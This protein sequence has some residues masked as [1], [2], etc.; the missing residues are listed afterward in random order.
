MY[1]LL[2][3]IVALLLLLMVIP[4]SA[5]QVRVF[6]E[7]VSVVGVQ[8]RDEMKLTVQTLLAS[9]LSGDNIIAVG[10]PGD[11]DVLVKSTYVTVGKVFSVDAVARTSGGST[12]TR[13]FVQGESQDELIPSVGKLAEKLSTELIR[14]NQGSGMSSFANAKA[15][16]APSSEIIKHDQQQVRRAPAGD[17]IKPIYEQRSTGGWLSKRLTG[18]ANLIALGKSLNDGSREV[19]M[20]EN[21]RLSYYRQGTDIKLSAEV[22]FSSAEKII[23]L[24][25]VEAGDGEQ[26][27][28]VTMVR[29][30]EPASQVWRVKGE[31]LVRVAEKIPYFFRAIN[32][33]G[34]PKKLYAQ[35]MGRDTDFYGD[36][37][38]AS[39]SGSNIITKNPLKM[40]QY[41]NIYSFN[42]FRDN[43]GKI[44]TAA[45]TPDGYL[46]V[47]DQS[48][49][50]LWRSNDKYGGSELYF[51][52]EDLSNARI[53]SDRYRWIFMNQRIQVTSKGEILV[54]KNDGFWVLGNAR[55]YKKGAVF[56][57]A[58]N[59]SSLEEKWR[60]KDTQN[61]M[62]DYVF[63]ES[64]NELL[65][66]Q[67]VQR[68][69]LN[70]RGASS[71]A[72]KRVE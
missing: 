21:G 62:P 72:I 27:I 46:A 33:A 68:P 8:N 30:G 19:F 57:L 49:K 17:F 20:A 69:G 67:T 40:T 53:T 38:E 26:D 4:A 48:M 35:G 47:Y 54:G 24:D 28:Y 18:A 16:P 10:S 23:S 61:Y 6:V 42:Q 71:L 65:L 9:R 11:A 41:G 37:F 1:K 55:S 7:E 44:M 52:K 29:S 12:I 60:T 59:G 5:A 56:C 70:N 2:S 13:S 58:W 43:D 64:R 45:F 15:L 63:D 39:R 51:E 14:L 25:V 3:P 66:L 32:L 22:E 36:V 50:E 34:G 31:K